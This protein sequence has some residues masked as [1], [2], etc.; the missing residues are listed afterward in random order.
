MITWQQ[1]C[2]QQLDE[3]HPNLANTSRRQ[4]KLINKANV[5]A[6]QSS[7]N[8]AYSHMNKARNDMLGKIE[9]QRPL[10][11]SEFINLYGYEA[12]REYTAE[13]GIPEDS[14]WADAHR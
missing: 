2:E 13:H 14:K 9:K 7:G 11:R 12:W 4:E 6:M 8:P 1:F 3:V 5:L 10:R